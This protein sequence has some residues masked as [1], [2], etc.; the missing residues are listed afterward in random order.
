MGLE[1]GKPGD[2]PVLRVSVEG[3][4]WGWPVE[5]GLQG[6]PHFLF[7]EV[8]LGTKKL[9]AIEVKGAIVEVEIEGTVKVAMGPSKVLL[10]R[11]GVTV[12]G[13]AL[14]AG[15]ATTGLVAG[16]VLT[17]TAVIIGGEI[18]AIERGKQQMAE[19]V[20][21]T[22]VRD[23]AASR[24]AFEALG[25]TKDV[26]VIH[27]QHLLDLTNVGGQ[28]SRKGF[29]EGKKLVDKHLKT[30]KDQGD[31]TI[32]AWAEKYGKGKNAQDFDKLREQ[33]LFERFDAYKRDRKPIEQA[34]AEL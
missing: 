26:L 5:V 1:P 16:G 24:V 7:M 15:A 28:P 27:D 13:E 6:D 19:L 25:A 23:G 2:P 14:A 20:V 3:D 32:K 12:T 31:A 21:E 22:A 4:V 11:L 9:P 8:T 33:L 10:A 18:Y 34:I 17:V 30:F 29:E